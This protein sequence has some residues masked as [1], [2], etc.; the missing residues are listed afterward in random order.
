MDLHSTVNR[1]RFEMLAEPLFNRCV[2]TVHS[3]LKE[4]NLKPEDID[5]VLFVGGSARMPRFHAKMKALFSEGPKE[6][7]FRADVE[8]DEVVAIGCAVQAGLISAWEGDYA[9]DSLN[10]KAQALSKSIGI[11]TASGAFVTL[12][13]ERTPLPVHRSITVQ[14]ST[15][16]QVE[17]FFAIY[18]GESVVAKENTLLAEVVLSEL[19][20]QKPVTLS[21]TMEMDGILQVHA[22]EKTSGSHIKVKLSHK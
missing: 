5:Q 8:P 21:F 20:P 6:T 9:K 19:P 10:I 14:G 7:L 11:A 18:E 1:N 15:P 13:P 2:S 12:L 17:M 3:A 22:V 16:D 4:A